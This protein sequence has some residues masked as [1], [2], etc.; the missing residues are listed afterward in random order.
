[1][2]PLT[3]VS[4]KLVNGTLTEVSEGPL[5]E[6]AF[7]YILFTFCLRFAYVMRVKL[8]ARFLNAPSLI[9]EL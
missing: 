6:V 9:G 2:G 7:A 4:V 8:H 1:M 5:T 3:E